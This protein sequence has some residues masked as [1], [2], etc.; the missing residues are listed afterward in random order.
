MEAVLNRLLIWTKQLDW[1]A[2]RSLLFVVYRLF[3]FL[4]LKAKSVQ[5][6]CFDGSCRNAVSKSEDYPNKQQNLGATLRLLLL[7]VAS[8]KPFIAGGWVVLWFVRAGNFV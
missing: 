8:A 5:G 4:P 3:D 1:K 2:S 7:A 6:R